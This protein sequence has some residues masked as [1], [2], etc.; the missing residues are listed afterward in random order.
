MVV[1][2]DNQIQALLEKLASSDLTDREVARLERKLEI[3]KK[4]KDQ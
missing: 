1:D 3:L 4:A 2:V